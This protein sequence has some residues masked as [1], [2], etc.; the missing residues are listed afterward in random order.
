[1][2]LR[3]FV[4]IPLAEIAPDLLLPGLDP[5]SELA[6]RLADQGVERLENN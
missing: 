5:V 2:H 1:M 4:M 3:G 6:G